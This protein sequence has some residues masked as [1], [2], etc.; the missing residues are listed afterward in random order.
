VGL[1]FV[2]EQCNVY[3]WITCDHTDMERALVIQLLREFTD[4]FENFPGKDRSWVILSEGITSPLLFI[5][6]WLT[7]P[8]GNIYAPANWLACSGSKGRIQPLFTSFSMLVIN[9][10]CLARADLWFPYLSASSKSFCLASLSMSLSGN[11]DP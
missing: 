7:I 10:S 4:S 9:T 1:Q 6:D 8:I 11:L 3:I 5:V 2:V